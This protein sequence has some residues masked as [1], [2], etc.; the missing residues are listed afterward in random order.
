MNCMRLCCYVLLL[1]HYFGE[2]GSHA[3]R[4]LIFDYAVWKLM[5]FWC[6]ES[7][8]KEARYNFDFSA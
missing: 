8:K 3:V 1:R 5:V 7:L 4:G 6:N 2:N